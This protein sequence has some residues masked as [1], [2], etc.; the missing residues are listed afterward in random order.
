MLGDHRPEPL[1]ERGLGRHERLLDVLARVLAGR[2]QHMVVGVI[3]A[4]A[5]ED[6]QVDL[7]ATLGF[8]SG[9]ILLRRGRGAHPAPPG[10]HYRTASRGVCGC[11]LDSRLCA[12]WPSRPPRWPAAWRSWTVSGSSPSMFSTS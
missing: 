12:C 10:G 2:Q 1:G 9:G 6:L 11:V 7:V 5:F 8:D 3:R 4:G